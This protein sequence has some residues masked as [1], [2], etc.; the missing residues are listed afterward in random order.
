MSFVLN[1]H[2]FPPGG[3]YFIDAEGVRFDAENPLKLSFAI[4]EYRLLNNKPAGNP[5][6][7]INDFTCARYP[8]GCRG[9]EAKP[10]APAGEHLPLSARVTRW[11]AIIIRAMGRLPGSYVSKIEASRRAAICLACPQQASWLTG[12]SSC[13]GGTLRLSFAARRGQEAAGGEKLLGCK[14]LGEDTRTSV[15]LESLKPSE[16]ED[17]PAPCWRRKQ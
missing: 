8:T 4:R 10:L 5:I 11:L 1:K 15:F 16:R 12:C 7:E 6:Q 9:A 3:F 13:A 14:I 17:L 2:I